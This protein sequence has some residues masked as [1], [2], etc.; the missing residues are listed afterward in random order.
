VLFL[1][2]RG[3]W[4]AAHSARVAAVL[5]PGVRYTR[6]ISDPEVAMQDAKDERVTGMGPT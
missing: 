4:T 1:Y 6:T 2:V 3:R 5:G